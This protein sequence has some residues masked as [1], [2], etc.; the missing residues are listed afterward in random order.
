VAA[1]D[2][3]TDD[4]LIDVSDG[5]AV[6]T[7]NRPAAANAL[8]APLLR[9]LEHFLPRFAADDAIGAVVLTGAG[10]A[11]CAGGDVEL[12]LS[13]GGPYDH[14]G[15]WEGRLAVHQQ[16]QRDTALQLARMPKPT[17]AAIGGATA[18][19]G[20]SLALA[21]DLRYAADTATF[22]TAFARV[23]L[24]GDFG[25]SWLLTR[26]V[27]TARARELMFLSPRLRADRALAL[28]LV[29]DVVTDPLAHATGIAS[30]LA[31]GPREALAV[32]KS[33]L[34]LALHASLEESLD[35]DVRGHVRLRQSAWHLDAIAAFKASRERR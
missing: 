33:N 34:E 19:A 9:G 35:E 28:G 24:A 4:L 27:G 15:D 6:L 30:K 25:A 26:L 8:S 5:V 20:L 1:I 23:G 7:L 31:N 13:G 2:T 22:S 21:C 16:S 11:F 10:G 29:T 32:M 12:M 3:G 17:I 18:G 14:G